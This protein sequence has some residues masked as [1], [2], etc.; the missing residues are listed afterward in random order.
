MPTHSNSMNRRVSFSCSVSQTA[1]VLSA[2]SRNTSARA[3][4]HAGPPRR[5][6]C[7][8]I[9]RGFPPGK[10]ALRGGGGSGWVQATVQATVFAPVL[11]TV[12]WRELR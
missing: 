10:T 6:N 5:V 3:T 9:L 12:P 11:E 2:G 1:G 7:R 4:C 8:T